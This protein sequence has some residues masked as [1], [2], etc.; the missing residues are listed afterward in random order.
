MAFIALAI[1]VQMTRIQ[2]SVE[3]EVFR[4]QAENFAYEVKTFYPNRGEIYDRNGRLL[5]G[6]KTVYEIGVDLRNVKDPHAIAFAISRE[7]EMDYDQLLNVL[8]NPPENIAYL[9]LADFVDA[10]RRSIFRQLRKPCKIRRAECFGGLTGLQFNA[11]PQRSYPENAL[12]FEHHRICQPRGQGILRC[13]R[14]LRQP[15]GG[16]PCAGAR[17]HRPE[18][19]ATKFQKC[20]MAPP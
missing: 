16:Q 18:Q 8:N 2:N 9:V 7:L 14:N 19:S 5:A 20:P 12:G 10:K 4:Q 13:G 6:Q 3:A 11:H 1:I 17:P 15:A